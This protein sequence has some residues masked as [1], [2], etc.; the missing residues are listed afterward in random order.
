M[1]GLR[2]PHLDPAGH[3]R[4]GKSEAEGIA[5]PLARCGAVVPPLPLPDGRSPWQGG[6]RAPVSIPTVVRASAR[7]EQ[8]LGRVCRHRIRPWAG[9]C[10][11]ASWATL[12]AWA[13]GRGLLLDAF[14]RAVWTTAPCPAGR[15]QKMALPYQ[16]M[17]GTGR[18]ALGGAYGMAA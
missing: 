15:G 1:L 11:D 18:P 3:A 4:E 14:G 17:Q 10:R 12:A 2:Q 8:T 5:S 13:G 7:Q 16:R 9:W 6:F